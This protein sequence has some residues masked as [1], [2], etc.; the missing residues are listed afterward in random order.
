VDHF[1]RLAPLNEYVAEHLS[2]TADELLRLRL[3]HDRPARESLDARHRTLLDKTTPTSAPKAML[4]QALRAQ[5]LFDYRFW[6]I[7]ATD[8][9]SRLSPSDAI[10]QYRDLARTVAVH[11]ATDVQRR[12]DILRRLGEA[13]SLANAAA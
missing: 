3:E 1:P 4:D 8:S 5:S 10:Q 7:R 6:V 12:Q 13:V 2:R 11:H 9:L